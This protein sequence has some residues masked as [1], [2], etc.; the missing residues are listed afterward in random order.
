MRSTLFFLFCSFSV[1]I[2]CALLPACGNSPIK[3]KI[4]ETSDSLK[5][6]LANPLVASGEYRYSIYRGDTTLVY[7]I[8]DSIPRLNRDY[9]IIPDSMTCNVDKESKN[10]DIQFEDLASFDNAWFINKEKTKCQII[11]LYT[12]C[13]RTT[14][15]L[16]NIKDIPISYYQRLYINWNPKVSKKLLD[17]GLPSFSYVKSKI[18]QF[19]KQ[20]RI[21]NE[22]YFT[23]KRNIRLGCKF[24]KLESLFGNPDSTSPCENGQVYHWYFD[25]E[26]SYISKND[27][28]NKPLIKNSFG[29]EVEAYFIS[30]KLVGIIYYNE[31]P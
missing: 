30:N 27:I 10:I 13:I 20:A 1:L 11:G 31:V 25:G 7:N 22:K 3:T 2:I 21:V 9:L 24:S 4:K 12:D 26:N 6:P 23:T 16:F 18:H 19:Y 28:S 14:E 5:P 15:Y 8:P 29:Y 17:E